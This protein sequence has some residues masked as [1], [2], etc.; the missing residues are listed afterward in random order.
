[1]LVW[2]MLLKSPEILSNCVHLSTLFAAAPITSSALQSSA[3]INIDKSPISIHT[4]FLSHLSFFF[5]LESKCFAEIRIP[6]SHRYLWT[7]I[8]GQY[9]LLTVNNKL[10]ERVVSDHDF[11]GKSVTFKTQYW[12]K[13][14]TQTHTK[15]KT[16]SNLCCCYASSNPMLCTW[17]TSLLS[18]THSVVFKVP[19][20]HRHP[21]SVT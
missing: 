7:K 15:E 10:S 13:K 11:R 8:P 17:K 3:A 1:M 14:H 12:L 5:F 6:T 16:H 2:D 21:R 19:R 9:R 4:L 18:H 20:T